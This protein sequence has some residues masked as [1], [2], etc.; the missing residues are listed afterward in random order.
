MKIRFDWFQW[1][2][3]AATALAWAWPEPGATG[4]WLQPELLTKGGVALIFFLHGLTLAP[5]ALRAGALNWRLHLLVQGCTFLLFP[6][7]GLALYAGLA[8]RVSPELRLGIFFLC[9]LP[10]T[11][12]SSASTLIQQLRLKYSDGGMVSSGASY[13]PVHSQCSSSRSSQ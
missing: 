4:G 3:V 9:A 2:M 1:G 11:V 13:Q 7:I 6:L 5:A 8:G 10:S 12:S